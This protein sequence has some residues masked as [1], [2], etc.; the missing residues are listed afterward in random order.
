MRYL[1]STDCD[2]QGSGY[3]RICHSISSRLKNRG[4][5]VVVIGHD[6]KGQPHD[7]D[8]TIIPSDFKTLRS[9]VELIK[10]QQWPDSLII[11]WDIPVQRQMVEWFAGQGLAQYVGL[12]PVEAGPLHEMQQWVDDIGSMDI[13]FVISE[14]GYRE[15]TAA[16]LSNVTFLPVGIDPEFFKPLSPEPR[17]ELR[18]DLDLSSKFVFLTVA[19]N[20]N[21]KNLSAGIQT[22]S[23]LVKELPSV[24]YLLIARPHSKSLGWALQE[25]AKRYGV[26]DN[27]TI[28]HTRPNDDML[29]RFYQASDA[30]LCT[31]HAEGLGLPILEAMAC[32][33]PVVSGGWTAMGELIADGRGIEVGHEYEFIDP[34]GNTQRYFISAEDAARAML[35]LASDGEL[36]ERIKCKALAFAHTR[37][38]EAATDIF[39]HS[40]ARG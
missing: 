29:L 8:F 23:K 40:L 20:H 36:R 16:G 30:Y 6:Y 22:L 14:F 9:Q 19:D 10:Q 32:G 37:T 13:A 31:S 4:S 34:F 21:R 25:L 3:W 24:H 39:E 38:F 18:R 27:I 1:W 35:Q 5:E 17:E 11:S 2:L 33:V 7:F 12:F 26:E 28:I 15:C